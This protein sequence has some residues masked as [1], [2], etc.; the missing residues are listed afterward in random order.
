MKKIVL[1]TEANPQDNAMLQA[2]YSRSSSS[3]TQHLEKLSKTGSGKFMEQY[4]L[5]YGHASI[6]DCGFI[7]IYVEGVSMLCAK[8]IQDNQLYNGQE[9]SSRYI[10]WSDQEFFNPTPSID[11]TNDLMKHYRE[12]YVTQKPIL[13]DFIRSQFPI[14]EGENPRVYGNAITARA[15]DILRGF[16]PCGSTTN[17]SWTTSLRKANEHLAWMSSHPLEEVRYVARDIHSVLIKEYPQSISALPE[18]PAAGSYLDNLDNYYTEGADTETPGPDDLGVKVGGDLTTNFEYIPIV[19]GGEGI[20]HNRVKRN[21]LL[22]HSIV[23]Q[24]RVSGFVQLD[25]GSYRDLQRHRPGYVSVPIVGSGCDYAEI[26]PWY[27]QQLPD[28]SKVAANKLIAEI[29]KVHVALDDKPLERQ[30][31]MPMGMI[32]NLFTT[33]D[34]KQAI[35]LAELRSGST[36]HATLR[37]VAQEL[38]RTLRDSGFNVFYDESP[39]EWQIRRGEQDIVP[40]DE[41]LA[42]YD[43]RQARRAAL[44]NPTNQ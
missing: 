20:D 23:Y 24:G 18:R 13:I 11:S 17:L 4:Y 1:H 10:D 34:V 32:V 30:Y 28:E 8:A 7:T 39:D 41:A 42:I 19:A 6:A 38:A 9:C 31:F 43:A 22:K 16:L 12:F 40:T 5:G 33:S 37:P 29:S 14:K 27:Y 25:Y 2:L 15:F 26:H 3:V 44:E 35:Y 36:V 21:P